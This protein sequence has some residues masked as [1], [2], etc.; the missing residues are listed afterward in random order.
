[1]CEYS[2]WKRFDLTIVWRLIDINSICLFVIIRFIRFYV[3]LH[4]LAF[5]LFKYSFVFLTNLLKIYFLIFIPSFIVA[6]RTLWLYRLTSFQSILPSSVSKILKISFLMYV[7]QRQ[8]Y[9]Q[10]W[11]NVFYTIKAL[12]SEE[13]YRSNKDFI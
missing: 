2:Y 4:F 11:M 12:L 10:L 13:I 8:F 9:Q 6:G 5:I 1:M 7:Y 3:L